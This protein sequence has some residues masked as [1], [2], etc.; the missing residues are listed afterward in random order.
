[1][2][3]KL[4]IGL[5]LAAAPAKA[6]TLQQ[7]A[8]AFAGASLSIDPRLASR[9]CPGG[10]RFNWAS[11]GAAVVARCG[12]NNP[13]LVL[14]LQAQRTAAQ[15]PTLRRGDRISA[16]IAG[17]GFRIQLDAVAERVERDGR[18]LLRNAR[19]GRTIAAVLDQDGRLRLGD[20]LNNR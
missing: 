6:E 17:E 4:L 13:A 20:D 8:E 15:Q 3:R 5:L 12:P 2:R 14:P 18:V 1:M 11:S 7:A 10:H 19:S 16:D 9:S